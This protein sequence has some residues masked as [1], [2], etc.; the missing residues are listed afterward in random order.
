MQCNETGN[1]AP[2]EHTCSGSSLHLSYLV[3]LLGIILLLALS[4]DNIYYSGQNQPKSRMQ[5]ASE[6]LAV[7][8]TCSSVCQ[9]AAWLSV[10]TLP[11]FWTPVLEPWCD[12]VSGRTAGH[13]LHLGNP[14]GEVWRQHQELPCSVQ[15][16]AGLRTPSTSPPRARDTKCSWSSEDARVQPTRSWHQCPH[17]PCSSR[18]PAQ[19]HRA[20]PCQRACSWL[21]W[22]TSLSTLQPL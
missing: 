20:V 16:L 3:H 14:H 5:P 4:L 21:S 1:R 13:T 12:R 19:L 17:A 11:A 6:P 18:S 15:P 8:N 9:P 2:C 7:Q 10:L 22:V